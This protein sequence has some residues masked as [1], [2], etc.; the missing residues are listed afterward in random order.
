MSAALRIVSGTL[1]GLVAMGSP[2]DGHAAVTACTM[3]ETRAAFVSFSGAFNTGDYRRLN[4]LFAGPAWFRWYSSS[5]PGARFDPQARQ[6]NT[7]M[8]YFR[9]RHAQRDRFRLLSFT[10]NGNALGYGNFVWKM[11]RSAADFRAGAR[12]TVEAKGA[13]VCEGASARFI[14]MSV[15]AAER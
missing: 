5:A 15:G 7:L 4:T 12:F 2:T 13:A 14:V 3:R 1:V 9:A 6:R 11:E 10:F 8:A